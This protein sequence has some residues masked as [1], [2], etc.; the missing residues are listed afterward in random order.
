MT[1]KQLE[2]SSVQV[3]DNRNGQHFDQGN[4]WGVI[5]FTNGS[6][7]IMSFD[8]KRDAVWFTKDGYKEF[9]ILEETI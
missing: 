5:Y 1:I 8:L 4:W 7:A 2:V 6:D 3:I 9:V